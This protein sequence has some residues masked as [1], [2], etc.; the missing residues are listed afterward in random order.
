MSSRDPPPLLP[1][2][3][4]SPTDEV[5]HLV[6][7]APP[8]RR[9]KKKPSE[10]SLASNSSRSLTLD[11][12]G[13]PMTKVGEVPIDLLQSLYLSNPTTGGT[14]PS[15]RPTTPAQHEQVLQH[16]QSHSLAHARSRSADSAVS[17]FAA[18]PRS[19]VH[20]SR[21]TFPPVKRLAVKD[22]KRILVT[23]GAGFVGSHLV[24][25]LMC[26]GHDV[27]VLDNFFSGS[28]LSI[29]HW[30]GHPNFELVRADVVETFMV[31]VDQIYHLAC[32][33]SPKAYQH[34]A[35]K[36]LKTNFMGTMNMLGLAKRVK[37]RFL[38]SSTSEIY[39]SPEEHPQKETYWG[40]VNCVGPRACYDEGKRVAEAL[41]YGYHRQDNVDV[42]VA[43]IFNCYGP[44]MN[45]SDG[46][47]VSNF[48]VAALRGEDLQIYGDGTATR[49]LM[50]V[51]DLVTGLIKLMSSSYT[52]PVNIGT[53][54]EATVAEWAT[55]IRDKVE[56]M[57]DRGEIALCVAS[58]DEDGEEE[59]LGEGEG[60]EEQEDKLV[61]AGLER[62]RG[63]RS[64]IVYV[65]AVVDD[66]PRR[67][68]DTTRAKEVLGWKPTYSIEAG[69]EETIRY[70][71]AIESE[72]ASY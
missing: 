10:L 59:V 13:N 23:G 38:L 57:R 53:E 37:A 42:R 34:N 33:A 66:P 40:N 21:Q 55:L 17:E 24:D 30:G 54:D 43:R 4:E 27:V 51:H 58:D 31:E 44:R 68:P 69:I 60:E 14:P 2:L 12:D 45:S 52:D 29:S 19:V 61:L 18:W 39:G 50:F 6:H 49:S 9:P 62:P 56:E 5:S 70:F 32:P 28:K 20:S 71:S 47:L 7:L 67:R 36:T 15:S 8:S 65:D 72:S 48:I 3:D 26:L 63:R 22:R 16:H 11:R 1:P 46:R 35:V 25:R 64:E 41:T